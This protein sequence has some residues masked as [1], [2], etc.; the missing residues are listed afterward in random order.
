MGIEKDNGLTEAGGLAETDCSRDNRLQDSVS[1]VL[2]DFIHDLL[3]QIGAAVVHRH[4]D[5]GDFERGIDAVGADIVQHPVENAQPF[6]GVIFALERNEKTVGRGQGVHGQKPQRRRT[7]GEDEMVPVV[8]RHRGEGVAEAVQRAVEAGHFDFNP[9]E[10]GFGRDQIQPWNG[11]GSDFVG[12]PGLPEQNI[13]EASTGDPLESQAARGVG[14]GIQIEKKDSLVKFGKAGCKID[15]SRG[16]PHA[17]LLVGDR[18]D[19][20][21]GDSPASSRWA[22]TREK[23][24]S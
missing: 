17:A 3:R 11:S 8:G 13:V 7:I 14:L 20:C 16:F 9:T 21:H 2:A 5:T 15:G 1:E 23:K 19:S 4:D 12:Q 24:R 22:R 10:V 6:Q 18:E